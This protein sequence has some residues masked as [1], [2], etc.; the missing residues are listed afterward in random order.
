ME[1]YS[2]GPGF[3]SHEDEREKHRERLERHA[4]S[5]DLLRYWD[6]VGLAMDEDEDDF[7]APENTPPA[8]PKV[9]YLFLVSIPI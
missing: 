2:V 1:A 8:R 6:S 3:V 4:V 5:D 9:G 7:D